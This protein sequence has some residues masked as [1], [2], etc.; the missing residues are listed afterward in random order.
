[1]DRQSAFATYKGIPSPISGSALAIKCSK[2]PR[3]PLSLAVGPMV[4]PLLPDPQRET[5]PWPWPL[6]RWREIVQET[7]SVWGGRER[8]R[9]N[10]G[11]HSFRK[12]I[13]EAGIDSGF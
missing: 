10:G 9:C 4:A 1:M 12:S 5:H 6:S 8:V 2:T 3:G 11:Q 13:K 7:V